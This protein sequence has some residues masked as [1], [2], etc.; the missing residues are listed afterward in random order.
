MNLIAI[1]GLTLMNCQQYS[2]SLFGI[3]YLKSISAHM[4]LAFFIRKMPKVLLKIQLLFHEAL[5]T[6][7]SESTVIK[8]SLVNAIINVFICPKVLHTYIAVVSLTSTTMTKKEKKN[9]L[10][11]VLKNKTTKYK[12]YVILTVKLRKIPYKFTWRH[13][14]SYMQQWD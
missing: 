5:Q 13:R 8:I 6:D 1:S 7:F 11:T 9:L 4:N 10:I 3:T 2:Y 14:Q 12:T